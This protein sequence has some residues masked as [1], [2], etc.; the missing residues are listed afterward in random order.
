MKPGSFTQHI[1]KNIA[2]LGFIGYIPF[3]S[4]TFGTLLGLIFFLLLKP[5]LPFHLI[6]I[7]AAIFI[8]I[9]ASSTAERIFNEKDSSK[10]VIDEFTGFWVAVLY[11]PNAQ[12]LLFP[13][14][15]LFRFFD[16]IKPLGIRKLENTLNNG[17]GIMA[18][19]ILAGIYTNIVLQLWIKLF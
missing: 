17:T 8:G 11:L 13:A 6:V 3:A 7:F 2:T 18:D 16:I 14:F 19:D 10:I 12:S 4:G 9:Y 1:L 5:S 15:L